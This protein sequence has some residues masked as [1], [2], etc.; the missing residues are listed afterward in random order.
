MAQCV[1]VPTTFVF[2]PV[3]CLC[4]VARLNPCSR[5]ISPCKRITSTRISW[6]LRP[7]SMRLRSPLGHPACLLAQW[8]WPP[9]P[10]RHQDTTASSGARTSSTCA[11]SLTR[12]GG[13]ARHAGRGGA[14]G[15]LAVLPGR[16]R[17]GR[18]SR[19]PP[20]CRCHR[21][22]CWCP[23]LPP[24]PPAAAAVGA[25]AFRGSTRRLPLP[26][27]PVWLLP[28]PPSTRYPRL[29]PRPP[30]GRGASS[31]HNPLHL[32]AHLWPPTC[33]SVGRSACSPFTPARRASYPPSPAHL[34]APVWH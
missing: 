4:T 17:R 22:R 13:L 29:A 8:G 28:P 33:G 15:P 19:R 23:L 24:P 18:R 1:T 6:E 10:P 21:C 9:C 27:R 20:S 32:A 34:L 3:Q 12:G 31:P 5:K 25:V 30:R 7:V 11:L 14:A 16:G 26:R 2:P